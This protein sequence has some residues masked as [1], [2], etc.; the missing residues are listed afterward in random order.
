MTP[1]RQLLLVAVLLAA[2][3]YSSAQ[4]GMERAEDLLKHQQ[5]AKAEEEY[6]K[7][8]DKEPSNGKAWYGLGSAALAL[9]E[10]EAARVAF[11][12]SVN[13]KQ[14]LPFSLYNLACADALSGKA[15]EA[16]SSL[17]QLI[18]VSPLMLTLGAVKDP[19]LAGLRGNAEFQ[20]ILEQAAVAV[21]PCLHD[22]R[23]RAF[24]FW[25]GD[26]D[27]FDTKSR[28][29]V[30]E[31]HVEL[32]L[33]KCVLIENWA[34]KYGDTGKSFNHL[35]PESGKWRQYWV[36]SNG[37]VNTYEGDVQDGVMHFSGISR[38][39]GAAPTAVRLTFR[40]KPDG[41]VE[42]IGEGLSAG[43]D[44]VVNYDFTYVKRK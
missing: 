29:K 14:N 2:A 18:T 4:A 12:K 38:A 24:D 21:A 8:T 42:Q 25:I 26:W 44:W 30:G 36:S 37:S 28:D 1:A 10:Y 22:P 34:G 5:W 41:S 43:N 15:P 17:R 6:R 20:Q 35:D 19:D 32:S 40:P 31:S 16:L 7:V 11:Q 3:G 27:V 33:E 39:R 13:L 9:K 23:N